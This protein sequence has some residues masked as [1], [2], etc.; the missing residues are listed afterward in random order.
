[1]ASCSRTHKFGSP[2]QHPATGGGMYDGGGDL[3][4]RRDIGPDRLPIAL[5]VRRLGEAGQ[6]ATSGAPSLAMPGFS[7][8]SAPYCQPS[9]CLLAG[10][11]G[12]RSPASHARSFGGGRTCHSDGCHALVVALPPP[13]SP[14]RHAGR[15]RVTPLLS[16]I[17][18]TADRQQH[19]AKAIAASAAACPKT[20]LVV[21]DTSESE[22]LQN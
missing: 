17:I 21:S 5:E 6:L 3:S 19:A 13:A 22:G 18:P 15:V 1:M 10:P 16:I 14:L 7:R 9:W 4:Q 20:E 2:R 11:F 8:L 12:G